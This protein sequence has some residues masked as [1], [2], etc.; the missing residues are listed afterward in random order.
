MDSWELLRRLRAARPEDPLWGDLFRRCRELIR[1]ALRSRFAGRSRVSVSVLDDLSQDVMERL[2]SDGRRVIHRF[3]GRREPAFEVYIRRIAENILRDQFRREGNRRNREVFFPADELWRLE[4]IL[5][6]N[7][8]ADAGHDP[9]ADVTMREMH[10]RV[11]EI[12][13]RISLDDRQRALNRLLFQLYFV[14]HHSIPQIARLRAVPLSASSIARRIR[15]IKDELRK[16]LDPRRNRVE[17]RVR[18]KAVVARRGP[19]RKPRESL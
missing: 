12:L 11:A 10:Q 1:I 9:E 8:V 2:V 3:T 19:R 7:P 15:L 6:E 5:A 16:S 4:A 17:S 14:D 13:R 18:N